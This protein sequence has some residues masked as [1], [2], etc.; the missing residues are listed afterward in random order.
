MCCEK[1]VGYSY[2]AQGR[3]KTMTG[4][5]NE[6][7]MDGRKPE[8]GQLDLRVKPTRPKAHQN[9]ICVNSEN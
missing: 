9:G 2:D 3:L 8:D 6:F 5:N 4:N 7:K 1:M